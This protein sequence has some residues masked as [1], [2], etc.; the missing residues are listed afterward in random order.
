MKESKIYRICCENDVR[1]VPKIGDSWYLE[2]REYRR[3]RDLYE[4]DTGIVRWKNV[5]FM[6]AEG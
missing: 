4:D 3:N 5:V 1:E 6:I 2:W